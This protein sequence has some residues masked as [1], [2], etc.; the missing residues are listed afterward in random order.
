MTAT[1]DQKALE[2]R[3]LHVP[4]KPIVFANVFDPVS[5]RIVASNPSC[6]AVATASYAIAAVNGQEDDSLDLETNLSSLR[7]IAPVASK[8]NKPLSVDL[9]DGYGDRLEEAVEA[10]IAVGASGCN[11]E[12]RD[13]Q[14]GKLFPLDEAVNRV[15]R[16]MAAAA[17]AGVPNFA[18]NART[19][20]FLLNKD[21]EDAIARGKAFLEAGANTVFV[22]GGLSR[23]N[24]ATL[25]TA[26]GG[27]LNVIAISNGL[28][29]QEIADLGVA[30]ISVGPRLWRAGTMAFEAEAKALLNEYEVM[31]SK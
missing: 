8:H 31:R 2:L 14:T 4:G 15:R 29:I 5:A 19:D 3:N 24:V 9:Q 18:L 30:R 16:V 26:F 17:K 25:S 12:D 7:L 22:W 28:T 23:D 27:K 10:I 1:A 13:N 21:I 11:L 6:T 20:T